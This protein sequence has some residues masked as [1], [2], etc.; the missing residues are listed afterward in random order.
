MVCVSQC[1][2]LACIELVEVRISLIGHELSRQDLERRRCLQ[3]CYPSI[4]WSAKYPCL[5]SIVSHSIVIVV[6]SV[7]RYD[8]PV[9]QS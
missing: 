2:F 4:L 3:Q 9:V 8:L 6:N 1:A 7:S 5:A